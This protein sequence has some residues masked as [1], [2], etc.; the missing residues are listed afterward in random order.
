M[1]FVLEIKMDN[2]AFHGEHGEEGEDFAAAGMEVSRLLGQA[3][4]HI[5]NNGGLDEGDAMTLLDY[6]GNAVG[7]W[8]VTS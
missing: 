4:T 7:S 1:K 2:A 5:Q 8:S 6:N 3:R